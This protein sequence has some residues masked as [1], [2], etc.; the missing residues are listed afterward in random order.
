MTE[1][2]PGFFHR[3]QILKQLKLGRIQ[4]HQKSSFLSCISQLI[5]MLNNCNELNSINPSYFNLQSP[6]INLAIWPKN[7]SFTLQTY[8]ARIFQKCCCSCTGYQY[9]S[10]IAK[11]LTDMDKMYR[12]LLIFKFELWVHRRH[13]I[14]TVWVLWWYV[15]GLFVI[16]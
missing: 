2:L 16:C 6:N 5:R 9:S 1:H 3:H 12:I 13:I 15:R 14:G 8:E 4:F 10:G 11:Y 7:I